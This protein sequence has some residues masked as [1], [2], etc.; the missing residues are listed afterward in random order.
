MAEADSPNL[1][2]ITDKVFDQFQ[3]TPCD[4]S[5][6][7]TYDFLGVR[8]QL[9]FNAGWATGGGLKKPKPKGNWEWLPLLWA[10]ATARDGDHGLCAAMLPHANLG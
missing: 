4:I 9:R 5:M 3:D 1:D 6:D 8:S 10:V 2:L 7:F